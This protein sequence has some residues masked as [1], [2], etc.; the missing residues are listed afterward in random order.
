[1]GTPVQAL[2]MTRPEWQEVMSQHHSVVEP[3][4]RPRLTRRSH[5][6]K[7]PVDDFLFEYYPI[8]PNKLMTW[9]PG[10]GTYLE[11]TADDLEVFPH[12]I[13]E[14]RN[15]L[16]QLRQSWIEQRIEQIHATQNFL[17]VTSQR[18]TRTGCFLSL[19]H[20]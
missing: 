6:L 15:N 13:Y 16:I 20:I 18:P 14:F 3:W 11:A 5:G 2:L 7:H 10:Y 17:T 1:M 12:V 4:V 8:S 19:I 9:H